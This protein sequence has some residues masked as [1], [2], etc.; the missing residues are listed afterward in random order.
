MTENIRRLFTL[1]DDNT[2][3]EA[4]LCIKDEFKLQSRKLVKKEWIIAGC[5]PEAYQERIV[6]MLQCLLRKQKQAITSY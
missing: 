6:E 3:K 4:L 2:K 1:M 5:I